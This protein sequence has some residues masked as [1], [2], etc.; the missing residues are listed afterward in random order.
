MIFGHQE[1][2]EISGTKSF[3]RWLV[4][5]DGREDAT[6]LAVQGPCLRPL[7]PSDVV[8]GPETWSKVLGYSLR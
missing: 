7:R 6:A 8:Q 3:A 1:H 4:G 2:T 5:H